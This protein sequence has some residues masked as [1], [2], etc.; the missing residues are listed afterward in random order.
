MLSQAVLLAL[1]AVAIVIAG[2]L[3]RRISAH[4]NARRQA[5][6][7]SHLDWI[8]PEPVRRPRRSAYVR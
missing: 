1:F 2:I 5:R 4:M 3:V 6:L 7:K 8:N